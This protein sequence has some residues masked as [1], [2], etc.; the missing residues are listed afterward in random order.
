[1]T[2]ND[3][4][5]RS[6]RIRELFSNTE[7]IDWLWDFLRRRSGCFSMSEWR[8]NSLQ[9]SEQD[10]ESI[11]N[12]YLFFQGISIYAKK[13]NI[14]FVKGS[15]EIFY[16]VKY[17]G[18]YFKLGFKYLNKYDDLFCEEIDFDEEYAYIDFGDILDM[19]SKTI[20]GKKKR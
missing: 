18:L 11:K 1:M 10:K 13:H 8:G 2:S 9:I 4:P 15:D 19:Y 3:T 7:Y 16:M 12:M 6:D 17:C 5:K 20:G 14:K